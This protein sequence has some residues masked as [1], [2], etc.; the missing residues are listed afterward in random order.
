[1]LWIVRLMILL[2]AHAED[3]RDLSEQFTP[4]GWQG[5]PWGPAA[6]AREPRVE[7]PRS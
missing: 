4:P 1:M 3:V 5:N 2:G 7:C 6:A